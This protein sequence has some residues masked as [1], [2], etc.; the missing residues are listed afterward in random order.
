MRLARLV[1]GLVQAGHEVWVLTA[2]PNYPDGRIRPGYGGLIRKGRLEGAR[3]VRA[4]IYPSKS[5]SLLKRM[6]SYLSFVASSAVVGGLLLPWRFDYFFTESPPLFLGMSGWLLSRTRRAR[7]IFNVSDLWPASAVWLGI[8]REGPA[9]RAAQRLEAFCYRKAWLVTGQTR[10]ILRDIAARFPD[11][12]TYYL[13]NGADSWAPPDSERVQYFRNLIGGEGRCVAVYAGLLGAAQDLG[14]L[15]DAM[16]LL[17]DDVPLRL[18]FVGEGPEKSGLISKTREM[19]LDNVLFL[20]PIPRADVP[21]LHCAADIGLTCLSGKFK[22]AVPSKIFD[23]MR[24]GNPLLLIAEGEAVDLVK[25]IGCGYPVRPGD[26]EGINEALRELVRNPSLR[27]TLGEKGRQAADS[28][29][30]GDLVVRN[31]VQ[32]LEDRLADE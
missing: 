24:A 21:A 7:W 20:D 6:S 25:E 30:D 29:F 12:E 15:L 31:F 11:V 18:V 9:L 14:Q 27:K 19:G 1:R 17:P 2:M 22:D 26:I 5:L 8:V 23:V 32:Y 16:K 10:S 4:F 3:I 28:I 13:P